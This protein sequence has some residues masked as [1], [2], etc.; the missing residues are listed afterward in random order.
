MKEM[1]TR[2]TGRLE[3]QTG[4]KSRVVNRPFHKAD[5]LANLVDG[6]QGQ[7]FK[8][9]VNCGVNPAI[10]TQ[11]NKPPYQAERHWASQVNAE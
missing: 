7:Y 9:R 10:Y 4:R 6:R 5:M 3:K 2:Y 1:I 8:L 11:F